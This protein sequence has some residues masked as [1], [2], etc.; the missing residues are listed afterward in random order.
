VHVALAAIIDS[1]DALGKRNSRA[2]NAQLAP[3]SPAHSPIGSPLPHSLDRSP[4]PHSLD[5]SLRGQSNGRFPQRAPSA[6]RA[7]RVAARAAGVRRRRFRGALP[8]ADRSSLPIRPT[9]L[10]RY[11]HM[12]ASRIAP[13]IARLAL[14]TLAAIRAFLL[15]GRDHGVP[16][17]RPRDWRPTRACLRPGRPRVRAIACR[18]RQAPAL[19]ACRARRAESARPPERSPGRMMGTYFSQ[20]RLMRVRQGAKES[21]R[22]QGQPPTSPAACVSPLPRACECPRHLPGSADSTS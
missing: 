5:P 22:R 10:V 15:L 14:A 8:T 21:H 9:G 6:H 4:L 16:C 18:W 12:F 2:V 7:I 20:R 3:V 19:R 11:E 13:T 1:A 17:E